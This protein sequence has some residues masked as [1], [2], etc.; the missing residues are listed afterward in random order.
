MVE[1]LGD[2]ACE[3]MTG[4]LIVSLGGSGSNFGAGM[5]GGLAFV[6][7][8][9]DHFENNYNPEM[10]GIERLS[11]SGEVDA[12]KKIVEAHATATLS[13]HAVSL[14]ENWE[15]TVSK[16]WKAVPHPSSPDIPKNVLKLES[17][18]IAVQT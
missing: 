9:D 8:E 4:G 3:Y 17:L 1:G 5:S 13:P 7:D 14:L 6:Y 18:N 11:D 12:L 15:R 10:V 16:F 2:H